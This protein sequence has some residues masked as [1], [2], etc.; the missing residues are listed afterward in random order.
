MPVLWANIIKQ[1]PLAKAI[2]NLYTSIAN[3]KI[4]H[5]SIGSSFDASIQ[6][7]Q[8]ISTSYVATP[9]EP[10][11]PG[12]WLT[13]ASM[14][15]DDD[16]VAPLSPHAAL[17]LLDDRETM[18]K[19]IESDNKD[20]TTALAYFIRELNPTKSLHKLSA[21]L[22]LSLEDM[23][24]LARHL[25]Y[26]RR[27]RAVPPLHIRDTYIVSPNC[28]LTQLS[29]ATTLYAQRFPTL[30]SLPNM[31]QL[32]SAKPKQYGYLIPSKDHK[33]A[34]ME[35]LAWLL[36]GGW[37]TQLRT[38]AWVKI[39]PSVKVAVAL[40]M[41]KEADD[42]A[43]AKTKAGT[44][45]ADA[46][47]ASKASALG[48]VSTAS[49][50]ARRTYSGDDYTS[51]STSRKSSQSKASPRLEGLL[52][53]TARPR[54]RSSSD[55]A[56]TSSG[57]TVIPILPSSTLPSPALVPHRPS[58][59][60]TVDNINPLSPPNGLTE[61]TS[62]PETDSMSVV[63][64]LGADTGTEIGAETLFSESLVALPSV[65]EADYEVSLVLSPHK[66]NTLESKW[67]AYV[68]SQFNDKELTE[69]WGTL[70]KHF[71]GRKAIEEIASREGWKRRRVDDLMSKLEQEGVLWVVRHW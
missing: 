26:W 18:L 3:N 58:P 8:A 44:T 7:P 50:S 40:Q 43:H 20:L 66:A 64:A 42:K 48:S 14:M 36:R 31:L 23:Q 47:I 45:K 29:K 71:N 32:L 41:R 4:A 54:D 2:F 59:L 65:D 70:V 21:S 10:Q 1:S 5:V 39:T 60:H 55:A 28:D 24:F 62:A 56:S 53:P 35:I 34:Y 51:N 12:L 38:F 30:P 22:S 27:A 69:V 13:T 52:S 17:L 46:L 33:A 49:L 61:S 19:E 67:L 16:E 68:G 37:A 63:S 57:R 6:I 15:A 11:L 25:I 9:T